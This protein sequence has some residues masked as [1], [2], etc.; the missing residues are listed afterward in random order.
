MTNQSNQHKTLSNLSV[1]N[2]TV[3][4]FGYGRW[5]DRN[6]KRTY[7]FTTSQDALY[8]II[9]NN[10]KIK[11]IITTEKTAKIIIE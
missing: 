2:Y 10:M 3:S 11:S 8:F 9:N 4:F 6:K 7:S 5:D 1:D